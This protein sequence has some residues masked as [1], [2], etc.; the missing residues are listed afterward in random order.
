MFFNHQVLYY[1]VDS[2]IAYISYYTSTSF[3]SL[4][5]KRQI[6]YLHS[7]LEK[8]TE[9]KEKSVSM[10][11]EPDYV[12]SS[13]IEDFS[14][15]YVKCFQHHKRN[16]S[17]IH[18]FKTDTESLK[19]FRDEEISEAELESLKNSYIGYLV[20]RPIPETF[21]AK[22]CLKKWDENKNTIISNGQK[23]SL[24]GVD[25]EFDS[26]P[27]QEQDHVLSVCAT[28]ALWCYFQANTDIKTNKILSPYQITRVATEYSFESNMEP[29]IQGLS[30]GMM[31]KVIKENGFT[32]L[33]FSVN[34]EFSF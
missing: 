31:G 5:T 11:I 27:L 19:K 32:P 25:F 30:I 26:I 28:S 1:S 14:L 6:S 29:D 16:C 9:G 18:L 13:F 4:K 7:Y 3:P 2:L 12:D 20:I 34:N 23:A 22:I 24:L 8:W 33:H 15:Y 17:R 10:I 21:L